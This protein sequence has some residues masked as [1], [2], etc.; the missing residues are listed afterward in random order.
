M[1]LAQATSVFYLDYSSSLL[2]GLLVTLG[3]VLH[4]AAKVGYLKV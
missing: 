4:V 2:T 1:A 3:S